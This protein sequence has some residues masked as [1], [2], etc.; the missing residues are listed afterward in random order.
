MDTKH[1][2]NTLKLTGAL[3]LMLI[4]TSCP[5][6]EDCND[7]NSITRVDDLILLTPEQSTYSQGDVVTLSLTI[8]ATNTYFGN[9]RNLF[10][11]TGDDFARLALTFNQLFIDNQIDIIKGNQANSINRFYMPYNPENDSYELEV[12]ITLNRVGNYS[13]VTDDTIEIIGNGCNRFIIDT[14]V[15]WS[16]DAIIEF[17]VQ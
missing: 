17:T 10:L 13:F 7:L 2:F 14:N 11:E 6:V 12:K 5:G 8:P 4:L 15:L 3:I 1:I 9:E 16:G